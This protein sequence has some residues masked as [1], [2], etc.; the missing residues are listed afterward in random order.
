MRFFYTFEFFSVKIFFYTKIFAL[1]MLF[2]LLA[3]DK[4]KK[5]KKK[6]EN[7]KELCVCLS[8]LI[9]HTFALFP[10]RLADNSMD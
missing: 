8:T 3:N 10:N 9:L 7:K 6:I 5:K 2:I 4:A 1:K